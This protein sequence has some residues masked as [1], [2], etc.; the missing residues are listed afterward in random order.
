[1]GEF[2]LRQFSAGVVLLAVAVAT[3][4]CSVS[5]KNEM[6]FGKVVPP[7]TNI[8]R[9]VNGDEPESLDPPISSGQPEARIFMALYE[10][11]VEYHPKTLVPIPAIAEHWHENNDS[12]EFV[13]HLRHNARWSNG[14]P[15]T[16]NDFVY[17]IRR[18]LSPELAS[19]NA[20]L[21]YYMKYAEAYNSGAVF[22]K[23][24]KTNQFV[25][26]KD[27]AQHPEQESTP[28]LSEKT[29]NSDEVEYKPFAG[30]AEL[31]TDTSF[32]QFMHS[33]ARLT[34][35]GNEDARGKAGIRAAL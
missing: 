24:S 33:P 4:S 11:L 25:L 14:E 21:A 22:V 7:Q 29:L 20:Y 27:V 5:A 6:F 3:T 30:E 34:L 16:A 8:L 19:R 2:Y 10:G 17:T 1:M 23:D 35:S 31:A 28:P 9:Y 13:F 18:G 32:H 15:I 26:E 12:S